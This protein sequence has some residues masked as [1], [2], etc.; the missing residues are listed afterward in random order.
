MNEFLK[1]LQ[2]LSEEELNE[3]DVFLQ[4]RIIVKNDFL[5][6]EGQISSEI[7]FV[8]SGILRSYYTT[9][10]GEEITNCITFGG[11]LMSAY[12]SF[13]TQ[14]PTSEYIQAIT[15]TR[16]EVINRTDLLSLY[17]K[18]IRWQEV[19][20]VLSEMQYVELEKRIASFQKQNAKQRYEELLVDHPEYIQ[21][22]PLNNLASFLGITTRHLSRLRKD[23]SL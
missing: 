8:K 16:L 9:I 23:I 15:D 21:F 4:E 5:I 11:E 10:K 3:I 18:S 7:V 13:I 2:I 20:R 6:R 14:T 12:S 17:K 22:I 1:S 19:G